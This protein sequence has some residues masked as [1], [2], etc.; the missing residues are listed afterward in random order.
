MNGND[1][2]SGAIL[3]A[4]LFILAGWLVLLG[5]LVLD[6]D[7][8]DEV[9][10]RRVALLGSLEAVAFAAAGALFGTTVQKQRVADARQNADKAEERAK[11]NAAAAADGKALAAAVKTRSKASAG[12]KPE[13]LSAADDELL[14]LANRLLPD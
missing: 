10:G 5:W 7:A 8:A 3:Y 11:E 6:A 12:A 13:S 1:K 9:W 14:T 2:P 4:A